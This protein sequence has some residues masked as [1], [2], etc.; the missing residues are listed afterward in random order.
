MFIKLFS[1]IFNNRNKKKINYFYYI[2]DKI[3]DLKKIFSKYSDFIIK[4]NT[5]IYCKILSYNKNNSNYILPYVFTNIYEAIKRIFGIELFDVQLLGALSL[6]Y[7]NIIEMK[8]GEGKTITSTLPA[9]FY[10]L[11]KKGVHII[12]VNEYLAKRD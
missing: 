1:Y 2:I 11:F 4:N 6:Y 8:T 12:T 9:Y 10:S 3:N 5:D 7:G